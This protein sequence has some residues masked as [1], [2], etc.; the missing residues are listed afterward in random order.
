MRLILTGSSRC[1]TTITLEMLNRYP[2]IHL[3]NESRLYFGRVLEKDPVDYFKKIEING[4]NNYN[5]LP[6]GVNRNTFV[7]DC[8]SILKED[9]LE[10]RIVS[11]E[12]VL[13]KD[14][15]DFFGDK[16]ARAYIMGKMILE[17]IPFKTIIIHRDG[18]DSATSGARHKRGLEPPWSSS[19]IDNANH[20]ATSFMLL[21][22]LIDSGLLKDYI[23]IRYED[24]FDA[25]TKNMSKI[26]EYLGLD[27]SKLMDIQNKML[28]PK[29]KAHVGYYKQH[30][31]QWKCQSTT[32]TLNMLKR[33]GYV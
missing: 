22:N 18:R 20:W 5:R 12:T 10:N 31:P 6:D 1:G 28:D 23:L 8:I 9:K 14:R 2:G 33:L 7:N 32:D 19:Y 16:G 3:M 24:Y 13:M 27:S 21:F 30:W 29:L 26:A 4:D 25:P 11:A 15:Y 17:D